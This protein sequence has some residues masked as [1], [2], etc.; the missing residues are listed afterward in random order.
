MPSP[1]L[2]ASLARRADAV[3]AEVASLASAAVAASPSLWADSPGFEAVK[4]AIAVAAVGN[5]S[6]LFIG[7]NAEVARF[8]AVQAG[9]ACVAY[10]PPVGGVDSAALSALFPCAALHVEAPVVPSRVSAR[11][12]PCAP[13]ASVLADVAAARAACPD[14][15]S[16]VLSE[17]AASLWRQACA[18]CPIGSEL[19][20]CS[21]LSVARSVAVLNGSRCIDVA[22]VAEAVS[23]W[24]DRR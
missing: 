23:Y 20:R 7:P 17:A 24:L 16:L 4:R 11:R 8:L 9:V 21:V 13:L 15:A 2:P 14:P 12:A 5:L 18:E 3:A 1:A 19:A 22:D 10:V 6:V